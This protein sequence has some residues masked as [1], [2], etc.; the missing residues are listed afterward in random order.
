MPA[1]GPPAL[2]K[3]RSV[4]ARAAPG[5]ALDSVGVF[6]RGGGRTAGYLE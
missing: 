2:L 6:F 3:D 5:K 4:S 1:K